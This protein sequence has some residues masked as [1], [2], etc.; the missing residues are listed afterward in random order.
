MTKLISM[1][2]ITKTILQVKKMS[3][4]KY[5]NVIKVIRI[6]QMVTQTMILKKKKVIQYY[7]NSTAPI[8]S[9][10]MKETHLGYC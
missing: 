7:A 6:V 8:N 10:K 9:L 2:R 1:K 3:L 4:K 5:R